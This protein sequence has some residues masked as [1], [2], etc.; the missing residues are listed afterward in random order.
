MQFSS[1][2]FSSLCIVI[3]NVAYATLHKSLSCCD[4][5]NDPILSSCFFKYN[6]PHELQS[7]QK[8]LGGSV[9]GGLGNQLFVM[10]STMSY[11]I[12]HDLPFIFDYNPD[13]IYRKTHWEG[14]YASLTCFS[15]EV[16]P[17]WQSNFS[18]LPSYN[19]SSFYYTKIPSPTQLNLT[20][21]KLNGY[22]QS[23]KYFYSYKRMIFRAM[24]TH[25]LQSRVYDLYYNQYFNTTKLVVAMHFRIGDYTRNTKIYPIMPL[26][27]YTNAIQAMLNDLNIPISTI[28]LLCVYD[29]SDS[30]RINTDYLEPLRI[31]FPGIEL[32]LVDSAIPDWH[33]MLLMSLCQAIIIPN[34][35]F[36][37][38]VNVYVYMYICI[39]IP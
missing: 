31:M 27:Y 23:Y 36:A 2:L 10:F 34:S 24:N 12:K 28:S 32:M 20:Q 22:Y 5:Q 35:T 7:N 29:P 37:W 25:S 21:F 15:T 13:L 4:E 3:L 1:H 18:Y 33:Q 17:L 38:Y 8:F 6:K 19:E 26:Q 30:E 39:R 9:I 16:Y 11:A 14:M